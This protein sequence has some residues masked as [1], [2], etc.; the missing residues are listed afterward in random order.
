MT[1]AW[2]SIDLV[3]IVLFAFS[4]PIAFLFVVRRWLKGTEDEEEA[5]SENH[6]S[7]PPSGPGH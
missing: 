3:L 1:F 6:S 2:L 5:Q 4:L 7:K